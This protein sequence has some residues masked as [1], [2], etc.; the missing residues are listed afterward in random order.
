MAKQSKATYEAELI[1]NISK[2]LKD[3][4][5]QVKDFN[6]G[7][8]GIQAPLVKMGKNVKKVAANT[9]SISK[10]SKL[11]SAFTGMTAAVSVTNAALG[12]FRGVVRGVQ[13]VVHG[14]TQGVSDLT[15]GFIA[16][17]ANSIKVAAGAV[18][19][20]NAFDA[21]AG[22]TAKGL[23]QTLTGFADLAGRSAIDL[24]KA[25]TSFASIFRGLGAG[26]KHVQGLSESMTVLA[27]DFA[28]F[29]NVS[30]SE[31]I[32]RFISA[33]SGSTEVLDQF[34]INIRQ[35]Q[36]ELM[37]AKLGW[38]Q[39]IRNLTEYQ[40]ALIRAN[41]I[42]DTMSRQNAIGDVIKTSQSWA[43]Q[44]KALQSAW[45]D[46]NSELGKRLIQLLLPALQTVVKFMQALAKFVPK[47]G[48]IGD[49]FGDWSRHL[50][51]AKGFLSVIT[52]QMNTMDTEGLKQSFKDL[53]EILGEYMAIGFKKAMEK[54]GEASRKAAWDAA[55]VGYVGNLFKVITGLWQGTGGF[56][57]LAAKADPRNPMGFNSGDRS[58]APKN[59]FEQFRKRAP[60]SDIVDRL[61]VGA[62]AI[63]KRYWHALRLRSAT[64]AES[65]E[66]LLRKRKRQMQ[67]L[68]EEGAKLTQKFGHPLKLFRD[69]AIEL[70]RLLTAGAI[71]PYVY[72]K[73]MTDA[74][75]T[76]TGDS[77]GD[78]KKGFTSTS[79][80]SA[81]FARRAGSFLTGPDELIKENKVQ[82]KHLE[83]IEEGVRNMSATQLGFV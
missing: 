78:P 43:N 20:K 14:L 7:I 41:L 22:A 77:G 83:K 58:T 50:E 52:Q 46:L 48:K 59:K 70:Q 69:R 63:A 1:D 39:N 17:S 80:T 76:A 8:K 67:K 28:S 72:S 74:R 73:A 35:Q 2:P 49:T 56:A 51:F 10:S 37:A 26:D 71:T 61:A 60:G 16:F 24:R 79:S 54:L 47:L 25:A 55:P 30:D 68:A 34:G 5:S 66:E 45:K 15:R 11:T 42:M 33:L 31:G 13:N 44:V 81:A 21:V 32:Q 36:V 6:V 40:K 82:T 23:N 64:A 75:K 12:V 9:K 53:G 57:G 3:I 19:I 62:I 18:E 29:F 38:S 4:T 65:E 27:T